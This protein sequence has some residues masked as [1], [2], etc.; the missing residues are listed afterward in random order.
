MQ[1]NAALYMEIDLQNYAVPMC[2]TY[3]PSKKARDRT[4]SCGKKPY[5]Y[6]VG[7]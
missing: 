5:D 6:N 7:K 3:F 2:Y 1:Y 4:Y